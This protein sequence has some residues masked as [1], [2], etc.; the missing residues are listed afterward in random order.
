MIRIR[1][2]AVEAVLAPS[3]GARLVSLRY[4]GIEV[5]G[6]AEPEPGDHPGFYDGAFPMAPFAGRLPRGEVP[7]P[8]GTRTMPS[9]HADGHVDHGLV[10]SCRWDL[11]ER[12]QDRVTLSTSLDETWPFGGR[13]ELEAIAT[14]NALR[15]RLRYEPTAPSSPAVL[16]LHP[17][18]RRR[19]DPTGA[20]VE[21]RLDARGWLDAEGRI[22]GE[23]PPAPRD[24]VA[25]GLLA[26][27][28]LRWPG[29]QLRVTCAS[30]GAWIVCETFDDAV[31]VE[32]LTGAPASLGP[33]VAEPGRP[34]ELDTSFAFAPWGRGASEEE[35]S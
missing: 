12:A 22:T 31:C 13:V 29:L 2:G 19:L 26:D 20:P 18:F 28:V 15:V 27:P 34:I 7:T 32:P 33:P 14:A 17:W 6:G 3:R 16:G 9:S 10:H 8:G 35:Q 21:V 4:D 5:L 23:A 24:A 30:A 25:V 1:S 11:V